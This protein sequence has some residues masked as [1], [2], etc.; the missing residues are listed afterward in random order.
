MTLIDHNDQP[1]GVTF[2]LCTIPCFMGGDGE[3][4]CFDM[5][6]TRRDPHIGC[7]WMCS[8]ISM[9]TY[10]QV[11]MLLISF[12]PHA[13]FKSLSHSFGTL[14]TCKIDEKF[15]NNSFH[16]FGHK[17]WTGFAISKYSKIF[18]ERFNILTIDRLPTILDWVNRYFSSS[19]S[20][21]I[22]NLRHLT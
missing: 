2:N 15:G 21:C 12:D 7:G 20:N 19:D 16:P 11:L 9:Y 14:F 17:L 13:P 8:Y 22:K 5:I 1:M 10:I 18:L 3:T 4:S 6:D